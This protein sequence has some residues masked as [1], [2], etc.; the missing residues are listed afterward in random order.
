MATISEIVNGDGKPVA[1]QLAVIDGSS[2]VCTVWT[3]WSLLIDRRLDQRIPDYFW[4]EEGFFLREASVRLPE[5]GSQVLSSAAIKDDVGIVVGV[6]FRVGEH[7][8]TVR[9]IGGEL[10]IA[11]RW[12]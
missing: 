6:D 12:A 7:F 10:T 2:F 4:P 5:T 11:I 9:S 8:V 1:L 3:D